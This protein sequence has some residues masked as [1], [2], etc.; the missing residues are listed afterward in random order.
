MPKDGSVPSEFL[1]PATG[2]FADRIFQ[3]APHRV[4]R[5]VGIADVAAERFRAVGSQESLRFRS[6]DVFLALLFEQS[7]SHAGI[8]QARELLAIRRASAVEN[9]KFYCGE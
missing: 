4:E 3:V 2:A 7:E 6:I 9:A 1:L 5:T 8:E